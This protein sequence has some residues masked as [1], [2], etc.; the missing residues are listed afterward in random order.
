MLN[1]LLMIIDAVTGLFAAVLLLRF[2]MQAVRVRPPAHISQFTF[3]LSDWLVKPLRRLVPG[4]AGY[5]WASLIGALLI[6]IITCFV[7]DMLRASL[8]VNFLFNPVLV[9]L[10]SFFLL[11]KW[12]LYG[13]SGLLI[14]SVIFSWLNPNA[15]MAPFIN[16]L[17][18]PILRPIRRVIPPI[19]GIDLSPMVAL[20]GFQFTIGL[21]PN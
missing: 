6:A 2:W 21:L 12:I 8:I 15:P 11:I 9:F 7:K 13:W 1:N 10:L 5:D 4:V 20:I 3:Q 14:I 16:A 19:G 17:S 18:Y